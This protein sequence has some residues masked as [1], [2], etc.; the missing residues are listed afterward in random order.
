[1]AAIIFVL[2]LERFFIWSWHG[3]LLLLDLLLHASHFL[4]ERKERVLCG[5]ESV[6][7][8][9]LLHMIRSCNSPQLSLTHA[10]LFSIY[11]CM[12]L[13]AA[14]TNDGVVA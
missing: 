12:K 7:H 14:T 9:A 13:L 2:V 1:V 3:W 11:W 5:C 6:V 4:V 8:E 10:R